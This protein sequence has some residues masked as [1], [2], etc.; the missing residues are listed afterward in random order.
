MIEGY[1]HG[2]KELVVNEGGRAGKDGI[3]VVLRRD[4]VGFWM[5]GLKAE[6]DGEGVVV[7]RHGS[8]VRFV[9]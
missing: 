2:F 4:V 5:M 7:S 8:D 9:Q 3:A 6:G 1:S